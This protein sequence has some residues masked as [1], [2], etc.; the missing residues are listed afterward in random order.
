M[1]TLISLASL[2]ISLAVA[3]SAAAGSLETGS[4]AGNE[5]EW[6]FRVLLDGN[7]IGYHNF[8]LFE[9]DGSQRLTTEADFRVKFLFIT[10]FRY[11]HVNHETWRNNCVQ[12]IESRTDENGRQFEVKGSRADNGLAVQANDARIEVPGCVK[13]F[14]YWNPDILSEPQLLNSQTGEVLSVDIEK[15]ARETLNVRGEE[16]PAQRYRLEARNMKLDLWYSDDQQW[17]ALESTVKGGRK[18]R[19]ELT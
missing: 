9:E 16:I 10:A 12:E 6:N 17:L 18:L 19:Y 15:T 5:R 1:K 13:T 4:S 11:E 2:L 7:D 14:A 8:S 3:S